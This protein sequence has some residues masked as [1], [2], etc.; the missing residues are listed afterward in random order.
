MNIKEQHARIQEAISVRKQ[1]SRLG[2]LLFEKNK[3]VFVKAS[4]DF[5][6]HGI[7]C[8]LTFDL[9][10]MQTRIMTVFSC[11][12]GRKSGVVLERL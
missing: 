4:N 3:Q 9:P 11:S 10:D 12:P 1:I 2:V 7:P 5:V 6:K 8:T